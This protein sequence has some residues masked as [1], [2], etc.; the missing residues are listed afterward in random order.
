MESAGGRST[1]GRSYLR[2]MILE[3]ENISK[4]Y[5]LNDKVI[6]ILDHFDFQ[7]DTGEK[8]AVTGPSG[9]GKSTLLNLLNGLDKADSG[10]IR[11]KETKYADLSKEQMM[12][13]RLTEFG[14]IFQAFHLIS[15]L[16]AADNILMP[17]AA[18]KKKVLYSDL[19]PICKKLGI[20]NCLDHFPHQ[21]SGGEQQRVAIARALIGNPSVIFSDE[22]TGNL[23]RKNSVQVMDLLTECCSAQNVML[24][25]V[26][27]DE[28]LL[29]YADKVI[30]IPEV[31]QHES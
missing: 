20:E 1:G 17:L 31:Q 14:Y 22:A 16:N 21:L 7:A 24:I 26:T 13:L 2:R 30:R 10:D 11:F 6:P 12:N 18:R 3:A 25:F 15:T 23:D 4:S 27:H 5:K 28:S 8:I 19:E 9:S 29:R